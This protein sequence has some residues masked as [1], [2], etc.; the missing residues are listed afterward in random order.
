MKN[1]VLPTDLL[2]LS[3]CRRFFQRAFLVSL[4]AWSGGAWAQGNPYDYCCLLDQPPEIMWQLGGGYSFRAGNSAEGWKDTGVFE[5][6]G[7]GGLAFVQSH[8]GADLNIEVH[9][10]S[11]VLQGFD[12]ATSG[13]PLNRLALFLEYSQRLD[14]G[15]GFRL[16]ASPGLYSDFQ[17]LRSDDLAFPFGLSVIRAVHEELS[18]LLGVSVFPGFERVVDPRLGMRWAPQGGDVVRVDLFYPESL[19]TLNFQPGF[20]VHLGARFLPW[21]EYQLEEDDPRDRLNFVENRVYAGFH[22]D[23]SDYG[24]WR[25]EVG[26]MFEREIKFRRAEPDV[27]LEN[28]PYFGLS[29]TS[30]F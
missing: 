14:Y 27:S 15:W 3:T 2:N 29:Y 25:I 20:G 12:G 7:V 19:F 6:Y 30:L 16:D 11:R 1:N 9:A 26:Y 22:A 10:D 18:F 5:F 8:F 17:D 21:L 13:Y 23:T 24:R 4:F 28:A